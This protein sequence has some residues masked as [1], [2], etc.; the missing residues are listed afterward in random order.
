MKPFLIPLLLILLVFAISACGGEGEILATEDAPALI[1]EVY[2]AA[3]MTLLA[4][5][6]SVTPTMSP[7]PTATPTIWPSPTF[8]P[9]TPTAQSV[10]V[11]YSSANG[12]YDSAYVSDVT[13]PDGT[14]LAPD[15]SFTKTWN[16]QNIGSC[17]WSANFILTFETG[18][19]MEGD[20][21]TIDE[22]VAIG[23]TDSIS[24]ALVAPETEGTYTGYWRLATNN[25]TPFGQSVYVLIVVSE[26]AATSTPTETSTPI[27]TVA[28]IE[29]PT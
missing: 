19:D 2:T 18:E 7:L 11:S 26:D 24:V 4:Q 1:S 17:D 25:G 13:I 9:G 12:C 10:S 16:F 20:N 28:V 5:P 6:S 14:V 23:E 15:K 21:E 3:A 27:E 8:I 22:A 29:T